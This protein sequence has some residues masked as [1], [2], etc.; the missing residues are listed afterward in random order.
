VPLA[1]K[2]AIKIGG[3]LA[4]YTGEAVQLKPDLDQVP[5]LTSER[6]AQWSRVA[7]ADFLTTDEKRAMRGLPPL[8]SEEQLDE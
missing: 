7:S 3:W 4:S 6:D 1:S 2:V 8:Q 5:A